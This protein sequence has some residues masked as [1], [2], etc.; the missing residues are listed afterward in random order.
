MSNA[1]TAVKPRFGIVWQ[2]IKEV[3]V[4]G[5][6]VEN[7]GLSQGHNSNQQ[8]LPALTA[9]QYEAGIKTEW[10][11]GKLTGSLAWFEITKQNLPILDTS[12]LGLLNGAMVAIGEVRSRGV[13]MDV[14]DEILPGWRVIGN[15]AYVDARV[16]NDSDNSGGTGNVGHRLPNVPRNAASLWNTYELQDT[17]LRGLK[18]GAGVVM[19]DQREGD[20]TNDIQLPGYATVDLMA[21]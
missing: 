7:F 12:P 4:Y 3:S 11:G 14:A 21:S 5:N 2:P 10:F 18:F 13:E 8:P 15:Y 20:L 16:I 17:A 9:Q 19:R 1:E 6:Y